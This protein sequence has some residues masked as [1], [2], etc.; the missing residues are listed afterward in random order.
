MARQKT[1][2]F[3]RATE[4]QRS[5]QSPDE[6]AG[7]DTKRAHEL[8]D[9]QKGLMGLTLALSVFALQLGVH[10]LPPERSPRV[11]DHFLRVRVQQFEKIDEPATKGFWDEDPWSRSLR[12][13]IEDQMV[14]Q[15]KLGLLTDKRI[16]LFFYSP[17]LHLH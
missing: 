17:T 7:M 4:L 13:L 15:S 3:R 11:G 14:V 9:C 16:K 12:S 10:K 5:C 8:A 2:Q 1:D 6:S